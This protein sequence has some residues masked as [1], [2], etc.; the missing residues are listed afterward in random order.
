MGV[1]ENI[2][3]KVSQETEPLLDNNKG[4]SKAKKKKK[5]LSEGQLKGLAKG[6]AKMA[7]KKKIEKHEKKMAKREDN[8]ALFNGLKA[9]W[10]KKAKGLNEMREYRKLLS[11]ITEEDYDDIEK[12]GNKLLQKAKSY[13]IKSN[14][15]INETASEAEGREAT[16]SEA[17]EQ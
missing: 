16:A 7:E 1:D 10:Q 17:V 2:F 5:Q 6:R 8:K 11:D 4:T 14:N 3:I 9:T 12:L 13:K 15:N